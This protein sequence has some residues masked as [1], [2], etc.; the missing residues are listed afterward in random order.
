MKKHFLYIII[1]LS[2]FCSTS[3]FA[4]KQKMLSNAADTLKVYKKIPGLNDFI[5]SA[6]KNSPLLKVSDLQIEEM[7]EKI[8]KEKKSWS[9]FVFFDANAKY[10]LFNQLSIEQISGG[11]DV[12]IKNAREQFNYYAGITFRLPISNFINKKNELNI[13]DKNLNESKLRREQ[14]KNELT[15]LVID[16]YYKL[17]NLSQ[18][19]QINQE[20]LQSLEI[21]YLKSLKDVNT[22][23]I[24]LS[25][26]NASV[27]A[28]QKV[29]DT[30]SKVENEY[31]AQFFKIQI[32]TGLKLNK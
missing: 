23:T 25:D 28:K 6:L 12:S 17:I 2:A 16:E 11:A 15:Q 32:L 1:S 7:F 9:D 18:S 24:S 22:G 20:A 30:Y 27:T 3:I 8:K 13:L 4:Q 21:N 26:F 5:E 29:Q 10:G 31:F 14:V 19:M